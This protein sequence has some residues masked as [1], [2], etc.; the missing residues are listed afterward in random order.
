VSF[1]TS[2][3]SANH[4][5]KNERRGT[6]EF[7]ETI[8]IGI[9]LCSRVG[10]E[11]EFTNLVSNTSSLEFFLVL[12]DPCNLGVGVDYRWDSIVV[13][14]SVPGLDEFNSGNSYSS[15]FLFTCY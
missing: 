10:G 15:I 3:K 1:S 4:N 8:G 13:D 14:M 9:C 6:Y 2:Y 11:W 5:K 7:N 12:S